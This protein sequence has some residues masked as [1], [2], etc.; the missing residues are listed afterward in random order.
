MFTRPVK[1]ECWRFCTRKV[2]IVKAG[3]RSVALE[4]EMII[5]MRRKAKT[6]ALEKSGR[7]PRYSISC[8]AVMISIMGGI[9][10]CN[11]DG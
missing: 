6:V 3:Q 7:S 11:R 5:D 8:S 10:T 2:W 4:V 9:L 1:T